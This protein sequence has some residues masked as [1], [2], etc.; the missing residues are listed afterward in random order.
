MAYAQV[1][2]PGTT[3]TDGTGLLVV[4]GDRP[5]KVLKIE[6]LGGRSAM[7]FLGAK[8][9]GPHRE[10]TTNTSWPTWPPNIAGD[11]LQEAEGATIEP[12]SRTFNKN[13][14]E[15]LLGYRIDH[16]KYA[17]RRG[18]RVTYRIGDRTYRAVLPLVFATC[19]P[20]RDLDS[21]QEEATTVMQSVLPRDG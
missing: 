6:S 10:F 21:C 4:P 16:A 8:L 9:A 7:T 12:V 2:T 14:Y 11:P 1:A 13:G 19:P 3:F 20:G 5:A 18:V 17:V 15:L